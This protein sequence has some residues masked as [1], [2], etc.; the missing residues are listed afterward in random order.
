MEQ[1]MAYA[2]ENSGSGSTMSTIW[3]I[4]GAIGLWR[5]FEKAGEPG[6]IGII[7][8]YRDYKLCEKVMNN[9]WYW[10]RELIVVVPVIGWFGYFYFKYQ[11][12]KATA[13]AYGKPETWAWGYMLFEPIFWAITGLDQSEYYGPFG[14]GD[15]R[16]GEARQAK[17]VNFDV[18]KQ[19]PVAEEPEKGE[20]IPTPMPSESEVEFDFN[21][22]II[23]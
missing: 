14:R 19:E 7:P 11:I 2:E 22:D 17:T 15:R 4:I 3:F 18:I 6:W 5:M 10:V 20:P 1:L 13:K 21:Q 9:P 16:T 12:G 8:L 23:E